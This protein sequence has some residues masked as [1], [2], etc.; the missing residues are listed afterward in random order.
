MS[1]LDEGLMM[2]DTSNDTAG[3]TSRPP[4]PV[5]PAGSPLD[6]VVASAVKGFDAAAL[7]EGVVTAEVTN[8]VRKIVAAALTRALTPG[9]ARAARRDGGRGRR[10]AVHSDAGRDA[11]TGR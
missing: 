2:S 9:P 6:A 7:V 4:P 11:R 10:G 3:S 5:G 8:E 1:D